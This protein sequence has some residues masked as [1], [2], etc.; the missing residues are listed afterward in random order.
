M[1]PGAGEAISREPGSEAPAAGR[2]VPVVGAVGSRERAQQGPGNG[3]NGSREWEQ[4]VPRAGR[5]LAGGGREV[6]ACPTRTRRISAA[7]WRT[8]R[9]ETPGFYR[10]P[11]ISGKVCDNF[12]DGNEGFCV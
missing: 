8:I 7:V 1:C 11:K 3:S 4:P 9:L 6:P 5:V 2:G 10:K 12:S